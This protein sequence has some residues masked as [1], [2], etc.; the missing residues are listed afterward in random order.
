MECPHHGLFQ[1]R[2]T[3]MSDTRRFEM[4]DQPILRRYIEPGS[5]GWFIALIVLILCIIAFF[6]PVAKIDVKVLGLIFALALAR[7]F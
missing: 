1:P 2:P 5:L 6:F 3:A 4:P 7:L